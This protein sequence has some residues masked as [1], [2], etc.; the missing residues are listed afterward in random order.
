[1]LNEYGCVLRWLADETFFSIC[2]RQHIVLGN[3][4]SASTT[5]WLFGGG[6]A[7]VAH[8]FPFNLDALHGEVK[9]TWGDV[10]SIIFDHTIL[11]LFFPFQSRAHV[12]EVIETLRS[13]RLGS[14]KYRLGL[15]TGRFG[16]EHPLKACSACMISDRSACGVAYWHLTHQYPGIVL[17]PIHHLP[18][19]E[20]TKNRQWSGRFQWFL[21][22]E[23]VLASESSLELTDHEIQSLEGLAQG[24][25]QLANYGLGKSFNPDTVSRTYRYSLSRRA[26]HELDQAGC[27]E[28]FARYTTLLQRHPPL[29]SLP[30][31][32]AGAAA[33]LGQLTRSPRGYCH[34]LKHL[35]LISW[36]FGSLDLF[37]SMYDQQE[38]A[39]C[40]DSVSALPIESRL[41]NRVLQ[42]N[43]PTRGTLKSPRP[44]ILK[45][46]IRLSIL[47]R[48]AGGADKKLICSDFKISIS[49]VNKL[50]RSE[51]AIRDSWENQR[52]FS[53]LIKYR[54]AWLST[55]EHLPDAGVK[56]IRSKIPHIYAWLYRNDHQWLQSLIDTIPKERYGNNSKVDWLERDRKLSEAIKASFN[57]GTK[58]RISKVDLNLLFPGLAKAIEHEKNYPLTK[59][60]VRQLTGK[61]CQR[62]GDIRKKLPEQ[63]SAGSPSSDVTAEAPLTRERDA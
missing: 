44:K 57:T 62:I 23:N 32:G 46:P 30:T 37:V 49:T 1:M 50:I 47:E 25:R 27:G 21:P 20:S 4:K 34:P 9:A 28:S 12:E 61:Q 13:P 42:K 40:S 10:T 24:I 58:V 56:R 35:I 19:R 51:P 45:G 14:L 3:I 48:L 11:P 17:C 5:A 15:L 7:G 60:L 59:L 54:T 55:T 8:D 31:T 16:A 29:T 63:R 26:D 33:L 39:E 18:L 41:K 2:S 22:D 53:L 6:R 38:K 52:K 36:L 43:P